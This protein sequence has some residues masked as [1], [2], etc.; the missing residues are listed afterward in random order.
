MQRD[1]DN[2]EPLERLRFIEKL[3]PYVV[4]RHSAV[5]VDVVSEVKNLPEWF[6]MPIDCTPLSSPNV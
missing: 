1:F 5:S 2:I 3:L 4:P 6:D